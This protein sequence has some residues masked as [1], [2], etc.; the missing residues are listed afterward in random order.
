M[1]S[2][3]AL[4]IWYPDKCTVCFSAGESV[5]FFA[6]K[7]SESHFH[8]QTSGF[9]VCVCVWEQEKGV[10]TTVRVKQSPLEKTQTK[11]FNSEF[12]SYSFSLFFTEECLRGRDAGLGW[13]CVCLCVNV[14]VCVCASMCVELVS[15]YRCLS[16]SGLRR[17]ETSP[18]ISLT[19]SHS[20]THKDANMTC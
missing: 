18:A 6:R 15:E 11:H 4:A 10:W 12:T 14:C 5:F 13:M 9:C 8:R 3:S 2:I 16:T 19:L 20:H 1:K 7:Q 17:F